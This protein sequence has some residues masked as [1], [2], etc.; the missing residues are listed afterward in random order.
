MRFNVPLSKVFLAFIAAFLLAA[1][2]K[3][4]D[5][6]L[7]V[8]PDVE[9]PGTDKDKDKDKENP[10]EPENPYNPTHAVQN[11]IYDTFNEHYYWYKDMPKKEDLDFSLKPEAFF[12]TLLSKEDQ[13]HLGG[14]FSSIRKPL[15][16][17][18][19][20]DVNKSYGFEFMGYDS[21]EFKGYNDD[22]KFISNNNGFTLP[23]GYTIPENFTSLNGFAILYV[24]EGSPADIAGLKRGDFLYKMNGVPI[25]N[26]EA[27]FLLSGEGGRITLDYYT[28]D[29]KNKEVTLKQVEL[30][31]ARPIEENPVAMVKKFN[32]G[33]T[34]YILY[35]HFSPGPN[36]KYDEQLIDAAKK[37]KGVDDL[38]LDLRYN[39][40]GHITSEMILSSIICPA[41]VLDKEIGYLEF[42]DKHPDNNIETR[43]Y[44]SLIGGAG[45][46]LNLKNLYVIVGMGTASAAESVIHHM[47]P[48]MN[49][50][51]IGERTV[52]KCFGML[53]YTSPEGWIIMPINSRVFNM[54]GLSDYKDG[55]LPGFYHK[56]EVNLIEEYNYLE[57]WPYYP[58][59]EEDEPLL[60]M[61]LD[62]IDGKMPS[63]K[64]KTRTSAPYVGKRTF[65]SIEKVL[66][67]DDSK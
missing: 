24:V 52:G 37:L 50:H 62:I 39:N 28:I 43:T 46:N 6:I 44:S 15:G 56:K 5:P 16:T 41:E 64:P 35:H 26:M 19:I 38:I 27:Y 40:G 66:R 45:N 42:N 12:E 36:N 33:K 34:G 23:K 29:T 32:E 59:G 54:D 17:R 58:L 20:W 67:V 7:P 4:D 31:A 2:S 61:A 30:D 14:S 8:D 21:F 13:S 47:R 11:W 53:P 49:V 48:F 63:P 55:F 9:N 60:E 25:G 57:N 22:S 51:I 65:S 10:E 3:D 1:C 18:S